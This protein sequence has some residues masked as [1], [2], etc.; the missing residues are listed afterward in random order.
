[1]QAN[2]QEIYSTSI[3][4][5]SDAEKLQLAALVLEDV[6]GKTPANAATTP[7]KRKG[8]ITQLFGMWQGG[9]ADDTDNE[10]IDADLARVYSK[11]V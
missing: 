2:I 10:K 5:L 1:M 6:T 11:H 3:P 9:A 7:P 4:S 8:D